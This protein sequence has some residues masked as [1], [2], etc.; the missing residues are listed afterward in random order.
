MEEIT[1]IL[2][3]IP[4]LLTAFAEW[5]T[6]MVLILPLQK[7]HNKWITILIMLGA[8]AGQCFLQTHKLELAPASNV[9]ILWILA[10]GMLPNVLFMMFYIWVTVDVQKNFAVFLGCKALMVAEFTAAFAWTLYGLYFRHRQEDIRVELLSSI[11]S[12]IL[13]LPVIYLLERQNKTLPKM[14]RINWKQNMIAVI[15]AV[16]TFVI[17]NIGYVEKEFLLSIDIQYKFFSIRML[18]DFCG[19]CIIYLIQLLYLDNLMKSELNAIN[20]TLNQQYKQYLDFMEISEYIGEQCHDLKHQIQE[21]RTSYS[22]EEREAYLQEMERAVKLYQAW[23]VTGNSVLDSIMTQKRIYCVKHNIELT[24]TVDGK[25]LNRLAARDI[26]TIFGN[27][28]DNA[29]EAVSFYEETEK[30]VIHGEVCQKQS[31]LIIRF[32]NYYSG[33]NNFDNQIPET[34]KA[35]KARHGYGI[36]S[37]RYTVEKY[38]GSVVLKTEN[39]WFIVKIMIPLEEEMTAAYRITD[40]I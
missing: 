37:V 17:S 13:I 9:S 36:K 8:L 4:N 12:F 26:C 10:M 24:C 3:N 40:A 39:N 2:P 16:L 19:C 22:D 32:D 14:A 7:R 21:I 34:T 15:L 1:N 35:D 18:A 11:V 27:L 31:F 23:N 29:I 38:G 6:C 28:L 30:R 25:A 5:S 20:N 33:K